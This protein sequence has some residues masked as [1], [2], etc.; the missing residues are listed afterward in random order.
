VSTRDSNPDNDRSAGAPDEVARLTLRAELV[1]HELEI[2]VKQM[3]EMLTGRP[4]AE[5][6]RDD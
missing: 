1:V 6:G 3:T 5:R 2:V 4:A